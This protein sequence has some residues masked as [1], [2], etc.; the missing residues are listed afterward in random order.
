M[1][2]GERNPVM[3]ADDNRIPREVFRPLWEFVPADAFAAPPAPAREIVRKRV[4]W[5]RQRLQDVTPAELARKRELRA[6]PTHLLNWAAPPPSA[7]QGSL[8]LEAALESWMSTRRPSLP[9]QVV[10]GAPGS[11]VEQVVVDLAR[12]MQWKLIPPPSYDE[13]LD[14][15]REWLGQFSEADDVPLVLP[16]LGK[17]YLRHQEGLELMDR[18]LDWLA[19]TKRRCL[20]ACDSWAWSFLQRAVQVDAMLPSTWTLAPF[21]AE[22]LQF[23][24]PLL[25]RRT[26]KGA[27]IFRHVA[28]GELAFPMVEREEL[29]ASNLPAVYERDRYAEW[30]NVSYF[31]KQLAS[32]G[33]GVPGIAWA[34]WRQSLQIEASTRIDPD[35]LA[36]ASRDQGYTVWVLPWSQVKLP[37]I[38]G[39]AD[40]PE[41]FV[42]HA[43]LL[44]SGMTAE[45]LDQVLPYSDNQVRQIMYRLRSAGLVNMTNGIWRVT[46]LGYPAVRR[47]LASEGYLVDHF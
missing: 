37:F 44:H 29:D 36:Q 39:W 21:H 6:I 14:G 43:L 30:L 19:V 17:C 3:V 11:G 15:G 10:I 42:L 16:R 47:F 32:N 27:F 1:I 5:F 34:L 22:R 2:P 12:R 33:R 45:W 35:F 28:D 24:L 18:L 7:T 9:V 46:L 31:L 8:A 40:A 25:A 26:Y 23:W 20:I 41:L 38:P 4:D 13:I